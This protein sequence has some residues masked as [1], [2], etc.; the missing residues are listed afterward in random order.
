VQVEAIA[1]YPV[2]GC[3]AVSVVRAVVEPWG[4]AGDRRW[5]IVD[6]QSGVAMTQRDTALLTQL[7]ATP[8]DDGLV[9][10]MPGRPDLSVAC[11]V[12]APLVDVTVW[13]F[14]GPAMLADA[15]TAWLAK[16]LERE[17]RLVW[18]DDPTRRRV[19]PDR[20]D[21][22]SFADGFPISLANTASMAD[23]N[24]R[25]LEDGVIPTPLPVNRFRANIV[26]SGAPAW[27]EDSWTGGRIRVGETVFRVPGPIGRCLV[28]T[29]DQETGEKG[30]EPLRAL[31]QHR[32]RD[33]SLIFAV[34][35]VPDTLGTIAVG[36]PVTPL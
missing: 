16:A 22:V 12:D 36:D 7:A 19:E 30:H 35:L 11:P 29:I 20:P 31:G 14:T 6:A 25:M 33:S 26:I 13:D 3:R 17:V 4:L 27:V 15:A 9:L 5:L 1:L 28:T 34:N 18:L 24:D 21:T 8:T 10:R 23:L 2:K 32:R